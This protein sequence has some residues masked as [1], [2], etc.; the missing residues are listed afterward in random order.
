VVWCYH[1]LQWQVW[2]V[3]RRIAM[4]LITIFLELRVV[5]KEDAESE[6]AAHKPS[7]EGRAVP[8]P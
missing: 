6:Q 7:L 3:V 2:I 5:A 4:L 1:S 8:W